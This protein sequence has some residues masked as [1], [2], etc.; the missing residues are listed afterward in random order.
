MSSYARWYI[1][2]DPKMPES[3]PIRSFSLSMKVKQVL[4][5]INDVFI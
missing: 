4:A 1:K 5:V 3:F 2:I